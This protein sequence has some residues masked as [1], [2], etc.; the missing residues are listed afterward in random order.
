MLQEKTNDGLSV[1]MSSYD[2]QKGFGVGA[3]FEQHS[4]NV[5]SWHTFKTFS[6]AVHQVSI[7]T[8]TML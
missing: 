2:S 3:M 5:Q 8:G 4:N 7:H 6:K 1:A